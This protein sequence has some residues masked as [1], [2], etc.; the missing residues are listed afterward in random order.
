MTISQHRNRI[1]KFIIISSFVLFL[2]IFILFGLKGFTPEELTDILKI[3]VPIKTV[4]MTALIKFVIAN[5]N[6]E[7]TEGEKEATGL[8]KTLT[9]VTVYSHI[10]LLML[11]ITL[12]AFNIISFEA[13]TS[14]VAILETFFG[15][16]IGLIIADMFK[17]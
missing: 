9:N 13:L 2:L 16:Y 3:L 10:L 6:N 1:G 11:A 12:S 4:Y 8:Y 5:K 15:A 17:A 14:F 7:I